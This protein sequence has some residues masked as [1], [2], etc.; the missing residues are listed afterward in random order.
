MEN[1]KISIVTVVFNAQNTIERCIESVARQGFKNVQHI[2]IDGGSTDDTLK[3]IKNFGDRISILI[4]EPDQ[5]IYDAMNKGISLADGDVIGTLN[6]DDYL[7]N[8]EILNEIRPFCSV[9]GWL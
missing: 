3:I 7:A 8:D 9:T 2:I 1:I 5:G 4:S 6:S